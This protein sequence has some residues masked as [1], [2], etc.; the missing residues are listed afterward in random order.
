[1]NRQREIVALGENKIELKEEDRIF[2]ML[3]RFYWDEIEKYIH[4]YEEALQR[5]SKAVSNIKLT[6]VK[7]VLQTDYPSS[8]LAPYAGVIRVLIREYR[9]K[10]E[11]DTPDMIPLKQSDCQ[12]WKRYLRMKDVILT[13]GIWKVE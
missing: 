1:M 10:Y 2:S 7:K 9:E 6:S 8:D 11:Y 5:D 3:Y 4:K 12:Y 13:E